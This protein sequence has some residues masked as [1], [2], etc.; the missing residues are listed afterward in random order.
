MIRT[1]DAGSL[2]A[3]D[4]GVTVVL[5]GWVARRRDHGGVIFVDLRDGSGVAQVVFRE[6][7]AAAH[8]LRNEFCVK[9]TG[10]VERRPAGNENPDL[11]TGDVEVIATELE[12]L[13]EAA[14]LPIPVD[15]HIDAGDDLRLRYRYLDLR[16]SG[17]ASALKL[18]S[19]ANQIARE[20]LHAHQ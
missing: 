11:P 15:D 7:M 13:S 18:R 19:R 5:A 1:H 17:P 4:A 12:I 14:P 20:V 10:T 6:S 8:S 9:V 16:R 3:T 2:R